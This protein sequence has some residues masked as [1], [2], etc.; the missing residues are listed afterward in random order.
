[1][2]NQTI[3]LN[4]LKIC[5]LI[6]VAFSS[7]IILAQTQTSKKNKTLMSEPARAVFLFD[8]KNNTIRQNINAY[9]AMPI[10]SITKLMTVYVVLE[11]GVPLNDMLPV[12]PQK[13]ETSNTLKNKTTVSRLELIRLALIAS[14]NLAAKLL[15]IHHPDGYSAFVKKMNHTAIKLGMMN[16]NFVETTGLLP[17]T[18]T[19][20]DL[21]LL[22]KAVSEHSIFRES[23]MSKTGGL[24]ALNKKGIWQRAI[25]R[26]TNIFAGDYDIKVGKTGFTNLAGWCISMLIRYQDYEFDLIVLGSPDKKTRKDLVSMYLREYMNFITSAAVIKKIDL[27]DNEEHVF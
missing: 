17:N 14:D 19:A 22:N 12:I 13:S 2:Q 11:S 18:S 16:T 23:A 9:Q 24:D 8:H 4:Y 6:P 27:I 25:I 15:A 1:M 10:A 26:N 21:H 3:L 5:L 20:W 7:N